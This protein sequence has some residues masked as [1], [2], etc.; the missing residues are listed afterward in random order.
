MFKNNT[1][2]YFNYVILVKHKEKM[3]ALTFCFY[4]SIV[5]LCLAIPNEQI[6]TKSNLISQGIETRL[7][8][9]FYSNKCTFYF[10]CRHTKFS[11]A[12]NLSVYLS[13]SKMP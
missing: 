11:K 2:T 1:A 6:N 13:L 8:N 4:M 12:S 3:C 9:T 7:N 5:F 10:L